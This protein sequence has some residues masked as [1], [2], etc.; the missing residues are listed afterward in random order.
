MSAS[1]STTAAATS[2]GVTFH[3]DRT[4][5]VPLKFSLAGAAVAQQPGGTL[6][7]ADAAIASAS[8]GTM[9][10]A[11]ATQA[12]PAGTLGAEL[13]GLAEGSTTVTYTNGSVTGT[14]ALTV[15]AAPTFDAVA[16]DDADAVEEP[17]SSTGTTVSAS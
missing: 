1:T 6:T 17:A 11:N 13:V 12:V 8:I 3:K 15:V 9:T 2:S 10:A 4:E 14:L 7:V 5:F 16:F